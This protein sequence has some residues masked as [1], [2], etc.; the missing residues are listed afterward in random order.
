M[1]KW[2]GITLGIL[3]AIGGFVDVG[4][5]ATSGEAGAKFGLALVW[6]M[7]LGT[8][9]IVLLVEMSGRFASVAKKPYAAAIREH[10][11]F[12]FYLLPLATELIADSILLTAELGGVAIAMS[13]FTGITWRY[14]VYVAAFLVWLMAWRAPFKVIENAPSLL[15]LATLSFVVGIAVLGGPSRQLWPTLWHPQIKQGELAEY[16]YLSAAILGAIIS[17]Y[18]LFFYSSGAREEH[19]SRRSLAVNRATAMVGMGLGSLVSIALIV[20]SAMVLQPLHMS[21]STLGE[22]GIGLA[23]PLGRAGGLLFA[24]ALFATC[25]GAA[26]EVVLAVSYN[27]AQ[28]FGWE[29]GEEKRP[30][31]AARFNLALTAFLLVAVV[32]S[33]LGLDP[34]QL[35]L[36]ASA[37][38]ALFLPITLSP[39]LVIM[40]DRRYLGDKTN[41]RFANYATL[42]VLVIAFVVAIVSL[43]LMIMSGGG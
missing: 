40:N 10:F 31:E 3:T 19:W 4:A 29:W 26:L 5:V 2:L 16:L 21:A 27:V 7:L 39:F 12:K 24:T 6:A 41:G 28:G 36:Y 34:L 30:V 8:A 23:R 11:G 32:I 20:L 25:L 33:V 9:A 42:V 1:K 43:P 18:L 35:A 13:L 14:L 15:G 22:V 17:P 38:V 37:I